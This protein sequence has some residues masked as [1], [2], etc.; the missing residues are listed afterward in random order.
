[1]NDEIKEGTYGLLI[2]PENIHVHAEEQEN[3]AI[4]KTMHFTGERY[5]YTAQ[6]A[7]ET[8][9]FYDTQLHDIE[10]TVYLTF[11]IPKTTLFIWGIKNE[12]VNQIFRFNDSGS[13]STYGMSK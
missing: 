1:M 8:V 10:D 7:N 12:T 11:D 6:L 2:R 9:M 4:I 3:Q 13:L 5:Q